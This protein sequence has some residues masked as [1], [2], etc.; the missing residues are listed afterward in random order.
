MFFFD[1]NFAI[2]YTKEKIDLLEVLDKADQTLKDKAFD[3]FIKCLN[4]H[5]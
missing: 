3:L 1:K 5:I 2:Q 4:L